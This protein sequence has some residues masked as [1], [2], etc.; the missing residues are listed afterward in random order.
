MSVI[1]KNNNESTDHGNVLDSEVKQITPCA[2]VDGRNPITGKT[3]KETFIAANEKLRRRKRQ[4]K[5]GRRSR[6]VY[7]LS[8]KPLANLYTALVGGLL[9]YIVYRLVERK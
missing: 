6:K 8:Q 9:I 4:C 5:K 3:C 7:N 1:D 2:F